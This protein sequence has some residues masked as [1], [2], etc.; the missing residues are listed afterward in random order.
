VFLV[1]CEEGYLPHQ[2]TIDPR[3]TDVVEKTGT[4][5]AGPESGGADIEEERRLFYVGVTRAK[6]SLV[7]SRAR[8]RV[9]RGKAIPRTPSRFLMDVPAELLEE[10]AAKE[11]APTSVSEA[12]ANAAAILAM[13][14][15]PPK[16]RP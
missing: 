16:T 8:S 3:A 2:R 9:V 1:G 4:G 5:G 12:T 15:P 6:E 13:L 10:I 11:D 7:L 14:G